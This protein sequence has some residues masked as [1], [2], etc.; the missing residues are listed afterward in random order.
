MDPP[1]VE[2][3]EFEIEEAEKDPDEMVFDRCL[4]DFRELVISTCQ[5]NMYTLAASGPRPNS[6]Q[7]SLED[8]LH[9]PTFYLQLHTAS[10]KLEAVEMDDISETALR[11]DSVP[12]AADFEPQSVPIFTPCSNVDFHL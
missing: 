7:A 10:G 3:D 4:E 8:F 2:A 9:P 11:D 1:E 6:R 12:L 5:H